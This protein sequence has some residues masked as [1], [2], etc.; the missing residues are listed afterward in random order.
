MF[1]F[2]FRIFLLDPY[3]DVTNSAQF[4]QKHKTGLSFFLIRFF[5]RN[6]ISISFP[7]TYLISFFFLHILYTKKREKEV[8]FG[9]VARNFF[10]SLFVVA[11][12]FSSMPQKPSKILVGW[13]FGWTLNEN[14][15]IYQ[16]STKKTPEV[17]NK[18]RPRQ[19][20]ECVPLTKAS[21]Y[22][23]CVMRNA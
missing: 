16:L 5:L 20:A 1:Y 4:T 15:W 2:F 6:D 14:N 18:M 22:V 21:L 9:K 13:F 3:P 23:I 7:I 11:S 17:S 19:T 12:F 8:C 10:R